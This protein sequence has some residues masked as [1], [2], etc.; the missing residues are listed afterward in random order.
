[1]DDEDERRFL[2]AIGA[3]YFLPAAVSDFEQ[4]S[5]TLETLDM[6]EPAKRKP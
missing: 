5:R 6:H 2:D 3:R 1:M 4:L